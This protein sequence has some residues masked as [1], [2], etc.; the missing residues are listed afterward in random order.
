[1]TA[2]VLG[3]G[4][5]SPPHVVTA[6]DG[7]ELALRVAPEHDPGWLQTLYF[8]SG[9]STRGSVLSARSMRE[10]CSAS[11]GAGPTTGERLRTFSEAAPALAESAARQ[12]LTRAGVDPEEITHVVTVSCTGA[13]TPGL[14]HALIDRLALGRTVSRTHIGFMGCHGALNAL[15]VADAFVRAKPGSVVL[16]VCCEL[17]SLHYQTGPVAR[18]QIIAN[19]IFADGA[20]CA[21][22]G[23]RGVGPELRGFASR[24]FEGT[25]ELM[26]WSIG[27]HGFRMRLSARV[28]VML[29]RVIATWIDEWL[30]T[31]G[32]ERA[33]I[34][35]WCLHPGG[36]DILECIE[37]GLELKPAA[38]SGSREVYRRHGNMSSGTVLWV[39]QNAIDRGE[40]GPMVA[41]SF[42]P[43]LSGEAMLLD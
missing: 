30:A 15:A 21:V 41:I 43:G 18:D 9:V 1:M 42:G 39:M 5:A 29:R 33:Q 6:G 11:D 23:S 40:C 16:V 3:I 19:A 26:R 24:V 4:C 38:T 35:R 7:L 12:A 14:D 8:E 22:V 20:S 27:D 37:R 17:C 36:R 10:R 28:P 25:A 31:C 32:L 34:T 2:R 13:E